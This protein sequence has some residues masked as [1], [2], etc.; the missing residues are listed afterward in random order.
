MKLK[1][2]ALLTLLLLTN[3]VKGQQDEFPPLDNSNFISLSYLIYSDQLVIKVDQLPEAMEWS[4][5][6]INKTNGDF[7]L[8]SDVRESGQT[9]ELVNHFRDYH[10]NDFI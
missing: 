2:I 9:C 6:I 1:T 5:M 10:V 8:G 3:L 7:I 4:R